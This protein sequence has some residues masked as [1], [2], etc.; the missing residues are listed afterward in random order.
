MDNLE[1]RMQQGMIIVEKMLTAP[2]VTFAEV[3]PSQLPDA[4][5]VYVI[6][7]YDSDETLYVGR[8]KNLRQ[9]IY[10][11]H[12]HGP[13]SNARLKKYLIED[14]NEPSITDLAEAKKY[15]KDCCYVQFQII[16]DLLERGQVE[17]LLS[18]LLNVRYLYEEH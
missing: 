10:S 12:L 8:T 1:Y 3:K 15:L 18:F 11:N 13:L 6:K 4:P 17:G 9:R 14:P 5:G 16:D 2:K 7:N